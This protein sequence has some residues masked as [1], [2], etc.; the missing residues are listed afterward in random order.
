MNFLKTILTK[1][2]GPSTRKVNLFPPDWPIAG[3]IVGTG[4]FTTGTAFYIS[5]KPA[6][7]WTKESQP[8]WAQ[9]LYQALSPQQCGYNPFR[10]ILEDNEIIKREVPK[11]VPVETNV[12]KFE[13]IKLR[14]YSHFE[15]KRYPESK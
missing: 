9:T 4:I 7:K 12:K 13:T 3:I 10:I 8:L 1:S 11:E 5:Q 15:P 2:S 6:A 14:R